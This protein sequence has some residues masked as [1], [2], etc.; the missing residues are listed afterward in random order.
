[1]S[2]EQAAA[3]KKPWG[4]RFAE[5]TD[6]VV[7]RFTQSIE[8]DRHIAVDDVL[9]SIAHAE[10]LG[11]TGI[12][13]ASDAAQLV[14]GLEQ[15]GRELAEGSFRFDPALED[16]HMNVETRLG[17]I[18]GAEIAG[19]LH[20][21]RSR[22]DQ[23]A[24]DERLFLRRRLG[25][26][27]AR[28]IDLERAIVAAAEG[29][30]DVLVPGYTHLQRAQ[31][32]R[33]AH[34][35][36]AYRE[37]F[38][39][40]R[41]RV[42]DLLAR[43]DESPLGCG[44]ILTTTHPIDRALVAARLGFSRLSANSLDA[45]SDRDGFLEALSAASISMMH[46]SRWAEEL[47]LW[48]SAEFGFAEI[49]D[50]FT[51]GSSMMP[52]K[53]NPDVAELVRGKCGR[54]IGDLVALLVTMKGLPLAY[55]RD[56]QEDKPAVVDALDTWEA[57]LEVFARMVPAIRFRADRMK[58]AL[59]GGFVLA[60]ELADHLVLAGVPFRQ[61]HEVVGTIVGDL[62]RAGRRL[63]DL[64]LAEY[65]RYHPAFRDDLP[66]W[67]D[68]ERAIERRDVPGGPKASHVR[69][70]IAAAKAELEALGG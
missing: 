33:L 18:V 59:S 20:T 15:I 43:I 28:L 50:A 58:E 5:P 26:I 22:N 25:S 4:G 6:A 53:K 49:G 1:M 21:A 68:P 55:N 45:T 44:A 60:T 37:M 19:R 46:L 63:E 56:L 7:E 42:R 36:L 40:D 65:R 27:R 70:A 12:I 66:T 34:H 67:L 24:L 69:A 9:G 31:P 35:L 17:A 3:G 48:T 41:G 39:R 23:V 38:A 62:V 32:N 57:S 61:A 11:K 64:S 16:V 29:Q 47:V 8:A 52:Q 13:S 54:V 14:A 2:E 51:T 10:M 30:L